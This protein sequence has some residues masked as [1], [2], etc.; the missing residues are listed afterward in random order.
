MFA[1]VSS[2]AFPESSSRTPNGKWSFW[3]KPSDRFFE[4]VSSR[5]RRIKAS[6]KMRARSASIGSDPALVRRK[7]QFQL[8]GGN[9]AGAEP[10]A[11]AP[12]QQ[13]D[14]KHL[15]AP[16]ECEAEDLRHRHSADIQADAV[17]GN[18]E[19][20]A[21]DPW[22]VGRRDQQF[23]AGADR[24]GSACAL[25]GLCGVSPWGSPGEA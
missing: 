15:A 10:L 4:S 14:P 21:L 8:F 12:D 19:D 2:A 23:P 6:W 18:V 24:S 22:R 11:L 3:T 1:P 17:L 13:A 9:K 7:A 20:G 16:G 25:R 5:R